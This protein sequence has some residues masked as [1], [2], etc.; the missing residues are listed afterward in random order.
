MVTSPL[1][2]CRA[3]PFS[4]RI[5]FLPFSVM[6]ALELPTTSMASPSLLMFT[7]SMVTSAVASPVVSILIVLSV[8]VSL[9]FCL[10][11]G[12]SSAS[13]VLPCDTVWPFSV[14]LMVMSPSSM[15][16]SRARAETGR[17]TASSRARASAKSRLFM[18]FPPASVS[19]TRRADGRGSHRE[20]TPRCNG[21]PHCR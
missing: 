6:F 7:S 21:V 2:T 15:Y 12:A 8:V 1:E 11:T 16:Q 3:E 4:E 10:M 18:R 14:A 17:E 13:V 20:G 9:F 19:R 5:L